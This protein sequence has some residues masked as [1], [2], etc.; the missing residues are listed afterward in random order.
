LIGGAILALAITALL[1]AFV[2]QL[3]LNEHARNMT[4]AINDA[5]RVMEQLRLRNTNP[6]ATDGTGL[7]GVDTTPP[8]P[9]PAAGY[10]SWDAWL[11]DAGVNGG[12]G[13]S[14]LPN[15]AVNELI[16]VTCRNQTDTANCVATDDPIRVTV[17]VCWRHRNRTLGECDWNGASLVPNEGLP[18]P[19]DSTAIDSPAMLSTLMTCRQ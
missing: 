17:A 6:C 3:A 7:I 9:N 5:N 8:T 19:N 4:L 11:A 18:M 12:G 2:G 1:G 15:P 14:V 10:A 13:K 16:A